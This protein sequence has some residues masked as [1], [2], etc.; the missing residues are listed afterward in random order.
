MNPGRLNEWHHEPPHNEYDYWKRK[1]E[2]MDILS[3]AINKKRGMNNVEVRKKERDRVSHFTLRKSAPEPISLQ[4]YEVLLPCSKARHAFLEFHV[5]PWA[6]S[7]EAVWSWLAS[8][9]LRGYRKTDIRFTF[10]SSFRSCS[11]FKRTLWLAIS[12]ALSEASLYIQWH[13]SFCVFRDPIVVFLLLFTTIHGTTQLLG[14]VVFIQKVVGDFLEI[15]KMRTT[16]KKKGQWMMKTLEGRIC[17]AYY[18]NKA[19]LKR[20]KS[21]CWGLSTVIMKTTE[22]KC[23]I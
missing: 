16:N 12:S 5:G 13:F 8:Y 4:G 22:H 14:T 20:A 2:T 18:L 1:K 19:D 15:L 21:E 17:N 10:S 3:E 6:Q 11:S 9:F 7:P 23:W